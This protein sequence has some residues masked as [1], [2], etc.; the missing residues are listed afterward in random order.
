MTEV[1][2]C[3]YTLRYVC[4][5]NRTVGIS[6]GIGKEAVSC[7]TGAPGDIGIS[8]GTEYLSPDF[9]VLAG[10]EEFSVVRRAET[11]AEMSTVLCDVIQ[12]DFIILI[13]IVRVPYII[14]KSICGCALVFQNIDRF[15]RCAGFPGD[16]QL[17]CELIQDTLVSAGFIGIGQNDLQ[18]FRILNLELR[19]LDCQA[20]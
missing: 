3:R 18:L 7:G 19:C 1:G 15:F 6:I 13:S 9:K 16:D 8:I 2:N 17:D 5:E 12:V 14:G 20:F 4:S 11:L 10:D